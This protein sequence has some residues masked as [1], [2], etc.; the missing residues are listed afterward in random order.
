VKVDADSEE[1]QFAGGG[2]DQ[3]I[4]I[5]QLPPAKIAFMFLANGSI[6]TDKIWDRFFKGAPGEDYYS[7][8]IHR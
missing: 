1:G 8:Y 5:Q 3:G 4:Q 2:G 6:H 7:V